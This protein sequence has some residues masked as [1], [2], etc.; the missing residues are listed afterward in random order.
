[1]GYTR[2]DADRLEPESTYFGVVESRINIKILEHEISLHVK[3][4]LNVCMSISL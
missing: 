4:E 2:E 1:M 3:C